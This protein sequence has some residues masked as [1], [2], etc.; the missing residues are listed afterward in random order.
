M[1][2][3][4][5][6][7]AAVLLLCAAV[8][9]RAADPAVDQALANL[10][11]DPKALRASVEALGGARGD[12]RALAVLEA[13]RDGRLSVAGGEVLMRSADGRVLR[14]RDGAAVAEAGSAFGLTNALRRGLGTAV[15]RQQLLATDPQVRLAAAGALAERPSTEVEGLLRE[16]LATE[17]DARVRKALALAL[18]PL[19]LDSADKAR[20]L[21]AIGVLAEDG[22]LA[23]R[24]LLEP[25]AQGR[26][27]ELAQAAR[28]ALSR[29]GERQ[30]L[31]DQFG[32][33]FFGLSL[34]S[35]LLLAALGL[36][37][38]FGLMG[39]INMAHGEMLMIGAYATYVVQGL[40]RQ[41]LPGA[42]DW[43]LLAALPA[44]FVASALVGA[45]IERTVLRHL[46][47]RP[48]ETLL[49]TFG[50]SLILIQTVRVI[51]GAQNVEV[52]NPAWLSGGIEVATN[53]V[54]P[55]N[56]LATIVFAVL[57]LAG[58]WTIFQKTRLG[59]RV[60]SVTQNRGMAAAMGIDTRRVDTLTFAL[61]SGV[62][63]LG[64]VALSQLG[65]VGPEL[66]QAYIIDSFMVVVLGGV[67]KLAGAVAGA[68]GLGVVNKL[69]E[70]AVGAVLG[71]IALL[72]FI[73]L[74][75]QKRPQGLFALKGRAVES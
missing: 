21:A 14:A 5:R 11:A 9:A 49:A 70:P 4:L 44:A 20:R 31:R 51:F 66:G 42:F 53:L 62:A 36:A 43:Y 75:I 48:L 2:I 7:T 29:I 37:I 55:Y 10:A 39:V 67:G 72:G 47:G 25:I 17:A 38:T 45:A 24:G 54:L 35:V 1:P 68:L 50:I 56:R 71:K 73:I 41:Y 74:F 28:R 13:L 57:V 65:N 12:P 34:G 33:L 40:F 3:L 27:P 60:R 26:D 18:A 52:A 64:G 16:L 30:W 59:L 46:Y 15:A 61:G 69:L 8:G 23:A 19:D 63:G 22:E 6:L 32:N 58:V